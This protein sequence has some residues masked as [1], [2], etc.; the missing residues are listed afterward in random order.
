MQVCR[1]IAAPSLSTAVLLRATISRCTAGPFFSLSE[2]QWLLLGPRP[3]C[4]FSLQRLQLQVPG[5]TCTTTSCSSLCRSS[6]A[7]AAAAVQEQSY[8]TT[9][10]PQRATAHLP[11]R[12]E[13]TGCRPRLGDEGA[14]RPGHHGDR[15]AA[16]LCVWGSTALGQFHRARRSRHSGEQS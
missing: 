8:R 3:L 12:R 1:Q 10:G 16:P 9:I 7:S 4:T 14:A 13:V 11:T 15:G 5:L 2:E 6:L